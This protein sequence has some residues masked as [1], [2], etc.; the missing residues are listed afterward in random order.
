[1]GGAVRRGLVVVTVAVAS[2]FAF[3]A[4]APAAEATLS[5]PA[6]TPV[7]F[8]G[9]SATGTSVPSAIA[10]FEAAAGGADNLTGAGEQG[11]G[12]RHINWDAVTLDG[13]DPGSTV[14]ESGRVVSLSPERLQ[15]WGLELGS[16]GPGEDPLEASA[17]A[18]AGDGFNSV[19]ANAHFTPF[20]AP[21]VWA[22]FNS[23]TAEFDV[24]APAGQASTPVPAV[25][26]GL[27]VTFL[28]VRSGSPTE[29][30]YYNDSSLLYTQ[31][32]PAAPGGTSFAGALFPAAVVTRIVVTLGDGEI[33]GFNGGTVT[34]GTSPA[35][36]LVAG[37]DVVLA[38]PAPPRPAIGTTAGV[39]ISSVLDTF[40]ESDTHAFVAASIDWGDGTRS[41]GTIV[42]TSGGAFDVTGTHAYG[43]AG[44]YTA[45]VTVQ[46][47]SP[48]EQT[49][50]T[51]IDVAARSSATNVACSP[52]PVAV[53]A[54]TVCTA[55]VSDVGADGP[56]TPT[57]TVAFSSPTAGASFAADSGC[58]LGASGTPGEAICE[59][60]FTPTQLP[61]TQAR[62]D[63]VYGGDDAHAAS[64]DSA[65]VG[66]RAQRCTLKALSARL[67]GHPPVLGVIANCDARANVTIVG[68]AVGTRKGRF[69][70]FT[71]DFGSIHT[72]VT[73]GRPTV[74]VIK[75][76]KSVVSALHTATRRHQRVSLKLTL[77]ASSHATQTTTTT[78]VAAFRIG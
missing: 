26:R 78:R 11:S 37:D 36:D 40:T 44:T 28:N 59:V 5:V 70:A 57:G 68:K 2:V 41:A 22:P 21:N 23:N 35:A 10:Q 13:S 72:T 63:A 9:S 54:S 74:L 76:S 17:V 39:P 3:V 48:S 4:L 52:S 18:V 20:S 49:S 50:A 55:T 73:A 53:T 30:E 75:P 46:D 25:T 65:I 47:S 15:P 6:G 66:V 69:K 8:T 1:M 32:A 7:P 64:A 67:K 56:I 27:G 43:Q 14:I 12:Y 60:Q 62:I 58:V 16:A 19:N 42:P 24:V 71:L 34:A 51:V 77:T 45:E 38:E 31:S 33:F 29:I 61:P